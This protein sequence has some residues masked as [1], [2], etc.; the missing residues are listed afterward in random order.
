MENGTACASLTATIQYRY[1]PRYLAMETDIPDALKPLLERVHRPRV[2]VVT[3]HINFHLD[4]T[5]V[6]LPIYCMK[7]GVALSQLNK[8]GIQELRSFLFCPESRGKVIRFGTMD[9]YLV[10]AAGHFFDCDLACDFKLSGPDGNNGFCDGPELNLSAPWE[11]FSAGLQ[12]FA[13]EDVARGARQADHDEILRFVT[14]ITFRP[15]QTK[16]GL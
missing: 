14:G 5:Q 10:T 15:K 1:S 3:N 6:I 9:T 2:R 13:L 11:G 4:R 16:L 8:A 7:P 12:A